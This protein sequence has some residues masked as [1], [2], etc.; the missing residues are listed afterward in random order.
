MLK[1]YGCGDDLIEFDGDVHGEVSSY[2]TDDRDKGVLVFFSDGTISEVKYGKDG[3]GIWGITLK[4]KGTLFE[5]ID[6]C[7]DEGADIYSD[8]MTFKDGVKWAYAATGE[9]ERVR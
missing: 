3:K 9:W 8:I 2:G 7:V 1:V 6:V 5:N 4:E